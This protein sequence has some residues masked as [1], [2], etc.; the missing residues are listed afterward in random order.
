MRCLA[1]LPQWALAVSEAF[2][3]LPSIVLC[4]VCC[5]GL[6]EGGRGRLL[7]ASIPIAAALLVA[8]GLLCSAHNLPTWPLSMLD[9]LVF[10]P[11][12][13]HAGAG[14]LCGDDQRLCG[15][16]HRLLCRG[17]GRPGGG[18][19]ALGGLSGLA[20]LGHP[21][22]AVGRRAAHPVACG[23][24]GHASLPDQPRG[25]RARMAH[26]LGHAHG[27]HAGRPGAAPRRRVDLRTRSRGPG[28][29]CL[30][31]RRQRARGDDLPADVAPHVPI[32]A[33]HP[34]RTRAPPRRARA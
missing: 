25:G 18:R 3:A 23:K 5:T 29:H 33:A 28:R 11:Q 27:A 10:L 9:L 12:R 1:H 6:E 17:R 26:A 19:R 34:D 24:E 7:R 20:R 13:P 31:D 14:G 21:V 16:G 4:V 22:A 8:E 30:Y 2:V 15:G 32:R